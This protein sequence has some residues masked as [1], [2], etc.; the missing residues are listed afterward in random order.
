MAGADR[1]GSGAMCGCLLLV[2]TNLFGV[3]TGVL[4]AALA[5]IPFVVPW[6]LIPMR[7]AAELS[8]RGAREASSAD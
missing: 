7:R 6:F 3:T 8:R 1:Q 5:A 4:T 2:T